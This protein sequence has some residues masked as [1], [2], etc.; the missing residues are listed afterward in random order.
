MCNLD[1]FFSRVCLVLLFGGK[2]NEYFLT[3]VWERAVEVV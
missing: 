1:F 3:G 2:M